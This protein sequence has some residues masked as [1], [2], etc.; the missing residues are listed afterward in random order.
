MARAGICG[1]VVTSLF[2][3]QAPAHQAAWVGPATGALWN[4]PANRPTV[5]VPGPN[6]A[7]RIGDNPAQSTRVES[8]AAA[9]A[10]MLSIDAGDTLAVINSTFGVNRPVIL[11]GTVSVE[12]SSASLNA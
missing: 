9:F 10:G 8:R 6:T 12:G 4:T 3:A 7:P 2:A 11:D 1:L 5:V